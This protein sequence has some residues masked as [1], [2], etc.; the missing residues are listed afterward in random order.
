MEAGGVDVVVVLQHVLA[1][2]RTFKPLESL[3]AMDGR[4]AAYIMVFD[5]YK[6]FYIG[7]SWDVR[8]RIKQHWGA[9]NRSIG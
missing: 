1:K 6:Q 3:P 2:G 7:E 8:K 4:E 9:G 5:E